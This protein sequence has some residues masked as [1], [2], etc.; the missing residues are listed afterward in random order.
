MK[1]AFIL[2][3]RPE[4]IKLASV[5]YECQNRK[6]DFVLIHTNQHYS[7]NMDKVFFSELTLP[8]PKYNLNIGSSSQ[9]SQISKMMIS[10]EKVLSLEKPDV[11]IVQGDTNTVLAG[12][13]V[14]S[15]LGIKLGHVEAGLRS[16]D[17][18]MPEEGNRVIT[19]HISDIL[20]PPTEKQ[21][22][23][24]IKEGISSK[25]I[26][27]TG[28]TI[29]DAVLRY[30]K[31]AKVKSSILKKYNLTSNKYFL[32][33]CHRP[34]NTDN[35]DNFSAILQA[36]SFLA[37]QEE[38]Q[39]IFPVHPRN[40]DKLSLINEYTNITAIAPVGYLDLLQLQQNSQMIFSDSG[41][42]Q[43]ESC[44]LKK[45]CV[46]LR[47]NTE[48]PETLDSGGILVKEISKQAIL[49]AYKDVNVRAVKWNNPFGD[50]HAAEYILNSLDA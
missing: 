10:L 48:R 2:G 6:N 12:A 45:K 1:I 33:T 46:I 13:L 15:R 40:N 9:V 23:I 28:N 22:L 27:V 43:E 8:N 36:I 49:S 31:I 37:L 26:F 39:C 18:S 24:L 41:G 19:D 7:E 30:A 20:F 47:T 5:I 14:S 25:K 34:S 21:K 3:T 50:G 11:V 17:K 29:V 16:Y 32:L 44:V 35:L 4:I 38:A 42:I